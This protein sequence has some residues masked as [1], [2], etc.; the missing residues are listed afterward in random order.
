MTITM[1][2]ATESPR[3]VL[4]RLELT[5][6]LRHPAFVG[7]AALSVLFRVVA[8]FEL[9]NNRSNL[10]YDTVA[11]GPP[12]WVPAAVGL[13]I[14]AGLTATR[15]RRDDLDE[16][17]DASPV[18][19][20]TRIDALLLAVAGVSAFAAAG[21][22]AFMTV[23]RGWNGFPVLLE[24]DR[25]VWANYPLG[26]DIDPTD[27]TPSIFELA[28]GP[29]ALLVCG[30]LGVVVARYLGSRILI[31]VAPLLGFIQLIVVAWSMRSPTRWFWPFTHSAQKVGWVDVADDGS[32]ISIAQGFNVAATGW[33]VLY[34]LGLATV[35][36]VAA[37]WQRPTSARLL[38]FAAAG[39][40]LAAV[41][42][43][44]QIDVYVPDLNST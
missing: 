3:L 26:T 39:V 11:N 33:H 29:I 35:L 37:R 2:A 13:T 9:S 6:L 44:A 20:S 28:T 31:V 38:W 17:L 41:A 24:P 30:L 22:V 10:L 40:V 4:T 25:T 14:A 1:P 34:L 7:F 27:V 5:R 42:G 12:F 32:G 43:V 19:R 8:F 23:A 36:A 18:V 15:A 16:L 21:V